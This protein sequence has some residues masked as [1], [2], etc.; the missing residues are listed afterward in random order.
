MMILSM[1]FGIFAAGS[2]KVYST[3]IIP[4]D[5]FLSVLA[6]IGSFC[7]ILRFIWA[8]LME[9]LKFKKT[10]AILI[11]NMLTIAF[12]MPTLMEVAG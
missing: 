6:T 2:T 1:T 12:A 9:K 4:D 10:Y 3:S 5:R 7:G 11:I 8:I